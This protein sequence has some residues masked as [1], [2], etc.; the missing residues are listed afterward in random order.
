MCYPLSSP[1]ALTPPRWPPPF[2]VNFGVSASLIVATI[3]RFPLYN[4][5][6]VSD[7]E[8]IAF[9]NNSG[10]GTGKNVTVVVDS[11]PAISDI[12]I[13]Y[14][15]LNYAPPVVS[16]V[17]DDEVYTFGTGTLTIEGS[18]FGPVGTKPVLTTSLPA[19]CPTDLAG[20]AFCVASALECETIVAHTVVRCNSIQCGSSDRTVVRPCREIRDVILTIA[21]LDSGAT[22]AGLLSFQPPKIDLIRG[23]NTNRR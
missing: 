8:F 14:S 23:G 16:S 4:Y 11:N 9:Y 19:V 5:T 18:N 12:P 1:Y 20:L 22:G 7:G 21:G 17:N 6:L 13:S 10:I 3:D 15:V 2:R